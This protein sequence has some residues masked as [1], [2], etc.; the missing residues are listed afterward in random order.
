MR[1]IRLLIEYDGSDFQGWQIQKQCRTVQGVISDGLAELVGERPTI[2][3][4]GRTDSGVHAL[5]Q[6]ANFKTESDLPVTVFHNGL[7]AYL[8]KDVRILLAEEAAPEFH[9][10][11]DAV[12]R[13]YMYVISKHMRAVGRGYAW[14]CKYDLD[15]ATIKLASRVLLGTH[16]FKAFCKRNDKEEHYLSKIEFLNWHEEK[17]EIVMEICANRFLRSMV[18]MIV[19]A[20]VDVGRGRL[21]VKEISN[22]LETQVRS[23]TITAA[24]ARGLFLQQVNY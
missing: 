18:R 5:A 20:M 2:Y 13:Q 23:R 8:P 19:G 12:S 14:F 24:P 10:R 3:A 15:V 11:F 6:V 7:N 1:N 21:S 9:A 4:A 16:V 22:M 17:Q